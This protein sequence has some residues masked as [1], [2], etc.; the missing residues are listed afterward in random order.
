MS[1]AHTLGPFRVLGRLYEVSDPE[2]SGSRKLNQL[3]TCRICMQAL[4]TDWKAGCKSSSM[5]WLVDRKTRD[6]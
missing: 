4:V 6:A 2:F 5:T 3:E 1:V